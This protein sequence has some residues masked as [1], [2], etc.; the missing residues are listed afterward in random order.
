MGRGGGRGGSDSKDL[1]P[2]VEGGTTD[3][4]TGRWI[5]L[6]DRQRGACCR[7]EGG[8]VH[9]RLKVSK[10]GITGLVDLCGPFSRIK[11][12][13]TSCACYTGLPRHRGYAPRPG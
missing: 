6:R 4:I 9:A 10:R 12:G 7:R 1:M 13:R 2:A 3:K 8:W 5:G 11:V